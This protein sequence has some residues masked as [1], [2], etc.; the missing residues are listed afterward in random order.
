MKFFCSGGGGG[1]AFCVVFSFFLTVCGL[2]ALQ[3]EPQNWRV[4]ARRCHETKSAFRVRAGAA[5]AQTR[6]LHGTPPH[7]RPAPPLARAGPVRAA[8]RAAGAPAVAAWPWARTAGAGR[9]SGGRRKEEAGLGW[10]RG[11]SVRWRG[12]PPVQPRLLRV[13]GREKKETNEREG[14]KTAL[15]CA[16]EQEARPPRVHSGL[17]LAGWREGMVAGTN[18]LPAERAGVARLFPKTHCQ[19]PPA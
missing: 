11:V 12:G 13:W 14:A 19:R 3:R 15:P 5:A 18:G 7:P 1:G 9:W 16:W 6:H 4:R 8:R 2:T 17:G 10:G